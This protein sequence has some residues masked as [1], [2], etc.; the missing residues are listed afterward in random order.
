[1]GAI[2]LERRVLTVGRAKTPAGRGRQ[3]P[4]N[5]DLFNLLSAHAA[6]FTSKFGE[7]KPRAFPVP[8]R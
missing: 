4:M 5:A 8:G 2:D 6:W 7:T 1:L 3:I